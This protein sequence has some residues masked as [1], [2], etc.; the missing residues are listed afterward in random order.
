[1]SE[2]VDI[3]SLPNRDIIFEFTLAKGEKG[4]QAIDLKT[5]YKY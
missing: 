4:L 3:F 2:V 1:M 5:I